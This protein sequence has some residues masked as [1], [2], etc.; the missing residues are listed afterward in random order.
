MALQEEMMD[1]L[2][3]ICRNDVDKN[4]GMIDILTEDGRKCFTLCS[5][6][7]YGDEDCTTKVWAFIKQMRK[8]REG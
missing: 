6:E 7:H 4:A 1:G 2:C 3:I 5:Y 8:D